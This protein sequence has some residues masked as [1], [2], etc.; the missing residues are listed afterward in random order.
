MS[1]LEKRVTRDTRAKACSSVLGSP[2]LHHIQLLLRG[3]P[4]GCLRVVAVL[5]HLF[6]RFL[7]VSQSGLFYPLGEHV[8]CQFRLRLD[9]TEATEMKS[10][11]VDGNNTP[12]EHLP[13]SL[14]CLPSS[15]EASSR[16]LCMLYYVLCG[17]KSNRPFSGYIWIWIDC[18]LS[19]TTQL[20]L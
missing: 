5:S 2:F 9:S 10:L 3:Y 1:P 7:P 17:T 4:I 13:L 15:S 11:E 14:D 16:Q 18:C 12:E 19:T 8:S 20:I 6:I